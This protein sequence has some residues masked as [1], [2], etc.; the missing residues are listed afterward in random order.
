MEEI[1]WNTTGSPLNNQFK[2]K[3]HQTCQK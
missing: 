3:M 1:S 2:D